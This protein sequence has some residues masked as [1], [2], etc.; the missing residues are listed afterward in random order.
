MQERNS[1][2]DKVGILTLYHGNYNF[3]GLLQA[4]ALPAA[5]KQYLGIA[6]EQIDYV[7]MSEKQIETKDKSSIKKT[8]Y[9]AVYIVFTKLKKKKLARR[10]NAF[11]QFRE[12]I[13]HSKRTYEC[14]SIS[15]SNK[16]YTKFICGGDQIWNDY[17][18]VQWY[19]SIDSK[20]FTLQFVPEN[21]KKISYAPSMA[22]LELTDEF[23][24]EFSEK[25]KRFD[26]ISVREK[27]TLS[28]MKQMTN[29]TI[30]IAADPVLLLQESD[31]LKVMRYSKKRKQY[32]LCYLLGDSTEQRKVVE[33]FAAKN[34]YKV[35]VFP[36]IVHNAIRKCDLFFG[37]IHDYSSGPREFLGLI[38]NAEF[39]ITDSFHACVFS[40]IFK[41]PFVVFE[42]NKPGE[43]GNMNSRIYDFL[44]EYHLEN[45]L[46]TEKKLA[47]MKEIPKLDF[48]YAHEHWKKRREE[49]LE[50]LKNALMDNQNGEER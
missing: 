21:V 47:D 35:I 10:K 42:R 44:E 48:T 2:K 16:I 41:T 20:V 40:M 1:E 46:V 23:R 43:K 9:E 6:A 49:S 39:V 26:A 4:Y 28:V 33:K 34:N 7:Y 27:K 25:I 15:D 3:G 38:N 50:F 22:V 8:I 30:T 45:Q 5:I 32:V 36:H 29:K 18:I 19:R 31:W 37:D 14:D 24:K 13:P 11:E 12:F 17:H